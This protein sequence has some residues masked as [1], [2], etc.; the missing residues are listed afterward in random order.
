VIGADV[1]AVEPSAVVERELH[2]ELIA[3]TESL[4]ALST[5]TSGCA[6]ISTRASPPARPALS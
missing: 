3:Q 4:F 2:F 1:F 6:A 5:A